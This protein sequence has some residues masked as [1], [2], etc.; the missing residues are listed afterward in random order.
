VKAAQEFMPF[1]SG[2]GSFVPIYG[3]F[4][5]SQD[6]LTTFANRAHN[7][8]LELWLETGVLGIVVAAGIGVTLL[9][10]IAQAW[11][12][13]AAG[14]QPID[15]ALARAASGV[16]LLRLV[17]SVVDYPLR[18]GAMMA[19]LALASGLLFPPPQHGT[20]AGE[21]TS[22]AEADAVGRVL[23]R[24]PRDL[25]LRARGPVPGAAPT[26][27]AT[28]AVPADRRGKGLVERSATIEYGTDKSRAVSIQWPTEVVERSD[29]R[30]S[31]TERLQVTTE[32][33][34]A[35][36]RPA[37]AQP[38]PSSNEPVW[39]EAWRNQPSQPQSADA[40]LRKE[41]PDSALDDAASSGREEKDASSK[42]QQDSSE[43]GP[44]KKSL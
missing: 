43:G 18:T 10:G 13:P 42:R 27:T 8:L 3:T 32:Q 7:D 34:R 16:I 41:A 1:G 40:E 21:A 22:R 36:S 9:F 35:R 20:S 19:I 2:I 17:H 5:R 25:A 23:G 12:R 26:T 24:E 37:P 15:R 39:P 6:A 14:A 4:E 31:D 28:T 30:G 33:W 38:N 44:D 11:W 29:A